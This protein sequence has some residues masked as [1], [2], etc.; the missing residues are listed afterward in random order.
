MNKIISAIVAD[1]TVETAL[2][3]YNVYVN[4]VPPAQRSK[5]V[6]FRNS[7]YV[8]DVLTP[9]REISVS[10]NVFDTDASA[11]EDVAET[12][13]TYLKDQHD[14]MTDDYRLLHIFNTS[15][16]TYSGSFKLGDDG[17]VFHCYTCVFRFV[18]VPL[19]IVEED[20]PLPGD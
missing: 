3:G 19:P 1:E 9:A 16:P 18:F 6:V 4:E 5:C 7:A 14:Y 13:V 17:E 11:A 2:S 10:I 15:A 8:T 12:L 20:E